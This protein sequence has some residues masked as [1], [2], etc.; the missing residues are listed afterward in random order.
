MIRRGLRPGLLAA[1]AAVRRQRPAREKPDPFLVHRTLRPPFSDQHVGV[2][3]GEF[4]PISDSSVFQVHAVDHLGVL[5]DESNWSEVVDAVSG[6]SPTSLT[7]G[8]SR[9]VLWLS[10]VIP[11]HSGANT[12]IA[13]NM[14]FCGRN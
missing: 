4:E 5:T 9:G 11:I 7:R 12:L 3:W 10:F 8:R 13:K 6:M 2:V 1:W 14:P